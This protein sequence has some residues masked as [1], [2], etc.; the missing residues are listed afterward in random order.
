[1]RFKSL[2]LPAAAAAA[3]KTWQGI[4]MTSQ[5]L[6]QPEVSQMVHGAPSNH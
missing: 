5:Q 1:M 4:L 2:V 3:D 6:W